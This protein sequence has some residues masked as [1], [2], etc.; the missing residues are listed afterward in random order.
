MERVARRAT[1][2]RRD[3]ARAVLR[4]RGG[5]VGPMSKDVSDAA[6]HRLAE[7]VGEAARKHHHRLVTAESCTGGWIATT[8]K[9]IAGASE[10]IESGMAAFSCEAKQA[11]LGDEP[12]PLEQ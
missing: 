8:L 3:L 6:L 12:Q 1:Y 11:L 2:L 10:W 9:D 5:I 7:Q 4:D